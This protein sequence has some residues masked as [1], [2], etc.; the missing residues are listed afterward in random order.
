M[1]ETY[2]FWIIL[3]IV[4]ATIEWTVLKFILDEIS[5]LRNKKLVLNSS[6]LLAIMTIT[7]LTLVEF[8]INIKLLICIFITYILYKMNYIVDKWKSMFIS[9][10]YWMILI[11][12]DIIGLSIVGTLNSIQ[13]MTTLLDNNLLKLE[14]IMISKSLLIALIPLLKVIR[15]KIKINKKD[16]IYSS[17]PIISNIIGVIVIFE[18]IFK[19]KNIDSTEN[20]IILIIS[21]VFLL[22]NISL[23]SIIGRIIKDNNLR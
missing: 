11:G 15:L 1:L 23:I 6:L 7:I 14:L 3:T 13:N 2:V 8:N 19:D 10:L 21:I 20:L 5:E 17:I 4:S 18:F 12:F 9:L 22:S 16:C